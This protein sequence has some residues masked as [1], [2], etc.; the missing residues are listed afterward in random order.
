MGE[1]NALGFRYEAKK[2]AVTVKAPGPPFFD[3]L[4]IGLAIA[5]EQLVADPACGVLVGEFDRVRPEPLHANDGDNARR[6]NA[7]NRAIRLDVLQRC[8][9]SGACPPP[10]E[11]EQT[12]RSIR[13]GVL[14]RLHCEKGK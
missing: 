11:L 7:A 1:M 3:N 14:I 12:E 10:F 2:S 13:L 8:H 4:E 5:V 6:Q 9:R